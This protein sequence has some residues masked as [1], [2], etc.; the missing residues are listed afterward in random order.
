MAALLDLPGHEG[1]LLAFGVHR[2]QDRNG[3]H[4]G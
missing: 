2:A 3:S 4:S 1:V